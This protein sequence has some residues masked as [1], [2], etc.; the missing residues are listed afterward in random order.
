MQGAQEAGTMTRPLD[1][2]AYRAL[3]G[4]WRYPPDKHVPRPVEPP[5]GTPKV[6]RID[7]RQDWPLIVLI[8]AP[9]LAIGEARRL[10]RGGPGR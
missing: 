5:Y 6:S 2:H 4:T 10:M 9:L 1:P 3:Y 8:V 7:W